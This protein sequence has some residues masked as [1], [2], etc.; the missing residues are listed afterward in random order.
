M[1]L[2]AM[3]SPQLFYM[4]CQDEQGNR[5]VRTLWLGEYGEIHVRW[6]GLDESNGFVQ[7]D[8][9]CEEFLEKQY[10]AQDATLYTHI[11]TSGG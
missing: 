1:R 2:D 6:H 8:T 7:L 11:H 4:N 9:Q 3:Y 5:Y 10:M